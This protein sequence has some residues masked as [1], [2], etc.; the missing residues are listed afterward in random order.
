MK[1]LS[2]I[3]LVFV[4]LFTLVLSGCSQKEELNIASMAKVDS[5][6]SASTTQFYEDSAISGEE[7]LDAIRNMEGSITLATTNE[8]GSPNLAVIIPGVADENTL[9][10][11]I[12]PNQTKINIEE[13]KLA[14]MSVY[15]Y[16]PEAVEKTDRNIGAKLVLKLVEDEEKITKLTKD[17]DT[18]EGAM[19]F[20][21]IV[22]VLPLG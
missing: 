3:S 10:F 9:M 1:K 7:L 8:D 13:R 6:S 12:A 17:T 15:I 16:N 20:M 2:R 5:I 22:K 11:G 21:E 18:P 14:V 19:T 4:L